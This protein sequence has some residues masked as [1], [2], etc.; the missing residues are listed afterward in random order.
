MNSLKEIGRK[1]DWKLE[2]EVNRYLIK[3]YSRVN[4]N[5]LRDKGR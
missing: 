5:G 2:R 3:R 1:K 4:M